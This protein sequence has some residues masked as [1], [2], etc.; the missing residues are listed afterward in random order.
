MIDQ[1][2]KKFLGGLN[3]QF[4]AYFLLFAY[5]PLL[6]F[7]I[8][9][10]ALNKRMI[11]QVNKANVETL[12]QKTALHL[13]DYL[14]LKKEKVKYVFRAFPDTDEWNA[15]SRQL[16]DMHSV[17]IWQNGVLFS[18]KNI[19]DTLQFQL[20]NRLPINTPFFYNEEK[21]ELFLTVEVE[22]DFVVWASIP[23]D[24]IRSIIRSNDSATQFCFC[25]QQN[26]FHIRTKPQIRESGLFSSW[27]ILSFIDKN[28]DLEYRTH[29]TNS[30]NIVA[31]RPA[32]V[33]YGEL[34]K[35]MQE[36]VL[37]NLII[38]ILMLAIAILLARRIA[39]PIQELVLAANKFSRGDLSTPVHVRGIREINILS[40]EFE[41]MRQKLL[42]LHTVMEEKIEERTQALRNAQFQISHQEKMASLGL[43][44]AGVAHE[45]GNPLT[46]IS[47]M[48]QLIRRK[49]K[50]EDIQEYLK[51]I[52]SNIER[53]SRIVRELVDF[54]RPT[55]YEAT[56]VDVNHLIHS[57]VSIVRYD[58]RAKNMQ[59]QMNLDE[60]LPPVVLVEDQL[61]QVFLN[62]LINAVDACH[63]DT[64][65]IKIRSFTKNGNLYVQITDNGIGI[66]K[67]NL[68]KI[69][70]PFF[71]TKKVGKGT[72]LG[73]SVSYGIVK[74][75]G[76]TIS[77]ESIP[78]KGSTFTIEIPFEQSET[79]IE[80]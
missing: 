27:P 71:T 69:F 16:A 30:L 78:F 42:E 43:L 46:G 59:L 13:R 35:F 57:A 64:S 45:I 26:A 80:S 32:Y 54:A 47:S 74:N 58:K 75:L 31:R 40:D 4:I 56:Q 66:A 55:S 9:G 70:E 51:T 63:Q 1:L 15:A 62:I 23:A 5:V 73:L 10:Y 25:S 14:N 20:A 29:V 67:D 60:N 61:Q 50:D 33:V 8:I 72:G 53:I 48:A 28:G 77:V 34:K 21:K 2:W 68:P 79:L 36:I 37:A 49:V 52:L 38:G 18:V 11:Y 17:A 24:T 3:L 39:G 44:A 76:G 19:S 7:S 22:P 6:T 65:E 41:V 12:A